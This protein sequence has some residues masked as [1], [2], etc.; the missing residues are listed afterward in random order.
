MFG[1]IGLATDVVVLMTMF[2]KKSRAQLLTHI[3]LHVAITLVAFAYAASAHEFFWWMIPRSASNLFF[4]WNL[5]FFVPLLFVS[6]II[7]NFWNPFCK[8][9]ESFGIKS[10]KSKHS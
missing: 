7:A 1:Y 10:G 4:Y 5:Y 9:L 3:L 6:S 2:L 8:I